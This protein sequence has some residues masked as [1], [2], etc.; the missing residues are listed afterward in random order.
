MLALEL[1]DQGILAVPYS[2]RTKLP[3]IEYS[4]WRTK[5]P[6]RDE[7]RM[8]W[9]SN[10]NAGLQMLCENIACVDLDVKNEGQDDNIII[11][12]ELELMVDHPLIFKKLYI[13]STK[14][15]G[16]HYIFKTKTNGKSSRLAARPMTDGEQ[17]QAM[18][19]SGNSNIPL[20]KTLVDYLAHGKL[21]RIAPSPGYNT[22]QGNILALNTLTEEE[23]EIVKGAAKRL[24]RHY[25][26]QGIKYE[27]D[28]RPG[29]IF[30]Q[31]HPTYHDLLRLCEAQGWRRIGENNQWVKLNRP[32]ARNKNS[33][34]AQI[35]KS[36]NFFWNFSSS[37]N[38]PE[39]ALSPFAFYAHTHHGGDYQEAA[40]D[41][42]KQGYNIQPEANK[43]Q[44]K[45]F[46]ELAMAN[47]V[48]FSTDGKSDNFWLYHDGKPIAGE[49]MM[50]TISAK[51]KTF[52]STIAAAIVS[53]AI[54]HSPLN[55]EWRLPEDKM[56]ILWFDTEQDMKTY[57]PKTLRSIHHG[58][59]LTKENG[60]VNYYSIRDFTPSERMKFI[61]SAID[62]YP[63]AGIIVI[64]GMIDL[65]NYFGNNEA[66]ASD[67]DN[68]LK[69]MKSK[70]IIMILIMHEPES[71]ASDG[72]PQGHL[73]SMLMRKSEC[74]FQVK[75][76][77]RDEDNRATEVKLINSQ[78]RGEQIPA[79]IVQSRNKIAFT[80]GSEPEAVLSILQR[81]RAAKAYMA[82]IP[83]SRY[84]KEEPGPSTDGMIQRLDQFLST[85]D[86][87]DV[88][89]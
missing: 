48:R 16:R 38:Y 17:L 58:A 74:L 66:E 76:L 45:G 12:F 56:D 10:P 89:F 68:W 59:N 57:G 29:D 9:Q 77:E 18:M 55:F 7:Y 80:Q 83:N 26:R 25:D 44:T 3:L 36:G 88:P 37:E 82:K 72:K 35:S 51:S 63:E 84:E 70:G 39:Q 40:R 22:I 78:S 67:I 27:Q 28:Q 30:N 62:A 85:A 49:E 64:D 43:E 20:Y 53:G 14:S 46:L 19:S 47:K 6:S 79:L 31:K 33:V 65:S 54:G 11:D 23:V 5:K 73:G 60:R 87:D 50:I 2:L 32:D 4:H 42:H 1:Y 21:C 41:L 69:K 8:I 52:K 86:E 71:K 75:V 34:D 15:G 24:N 13:Q 61:E 81:E